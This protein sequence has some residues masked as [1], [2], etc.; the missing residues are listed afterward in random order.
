VWAVAFFELIALHHD[1]GDFLCDEVPIAALEVDVA[2]VP[3]K[4]FVCH[5]CYSS[6]LFT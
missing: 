5:C 3:P 2:D 4:Y 6:V 1:L